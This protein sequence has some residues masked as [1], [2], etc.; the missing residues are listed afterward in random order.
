MISV[1]QQEISPLIIGVWGQDWDKLKFWEIPTQT[2][3]RCQRHEWE[4]QSASK[5]LCWCLF[6]FLSWFFGSSFSPLG[7]EATTYSVKILPA[8]GKLTSGWATRGKSTNHNQ[9]LLTRR[10]G[11]L[12]P[13]RGLRL[14]LDKK[15]VP[16]L[17]EM[18]ISSCP[19][20][21]DQLN[22]PQHIHIADA[23]TK[24]SEEELYTAT[25]LSPG[26]SYMNKSN[27]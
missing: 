11:F 24:W 4:I 8:Q 5:F 2:L 16:V 14:E 25:E 15:G 1:Q 12:L 3:N 26:Y 17:I 7:K 6:F 10:G 9:F 22:K 19:S 13:D 21:G 23:S 18:L 27:L 20:I